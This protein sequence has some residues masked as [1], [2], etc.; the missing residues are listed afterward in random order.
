MPSE[1][2]RATP[3]PSNEPLRFDEALSPD[4]TAPSSALDIDVVS[5]GS[6]DTHRRSFGAAD[7][8]LDDLLNLP[9]D[10]V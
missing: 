10:G 4:V 3:L 2:G 9:D 8:L 1:P 6:P 7:T 5:Q